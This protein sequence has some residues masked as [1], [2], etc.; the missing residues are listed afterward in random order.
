MPVPR[1]RLEPVVEGATTTPLELFFDLV[2]VFAL[3]QVTG[4]MAVDSGPER[5]FRGLLILGL[6]WWS[7]VGYAWLGNVVKADEGGCRIAVLAATA[8]MFVIALAIPRAFDDRSGAWSSAYILAVGY[9]V[10]R[11]VHLVTFWVLAADDAA[12]RAQLVRFAA[13]MA[14]ATTLLIVAAAASGGVR[15]GL[16]VTALVADYAGT[17][18]GGAAGWRLRAASHFAERHGLI[19]LI[20]LGESVVAIGAGVSDRPLS[21]RIIAGSLLGLSVSAAL[22]WVYF[23][24]SVTLA[25]HA[26][27]A[28]G[29]ADRARLA[30]DAYSFLHLPMVA[31]IALAA[32]GLKKVL[33]V[34]SAH[35]GQVPSDPVRGVGLAA[36]VVGVAAYLV[37]HVA[38]L[39]RCGIGVKWHRLGAAVGV[40][41][42][43]AI[44]PHIPALATLAALTLAVTAILG[45][46]TRHFAEQR[47]LV[48]RADQT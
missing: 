6:M 35:G 40:L 13:S 18:L 20:A 30:R 34:L 16:W 15:T 5:T 41:P 11:A 9:F 48:R 38:F 43:L 1:L 37:A 46:E 25:E 12:L 17:Y 36:L 28:S 21:G 3:T 14:T 19:V 8:A 31:G 47:R 22:W 2:F 7:W 44:G 10:L 26:L 23:D 33:G 42:L 4:F 29:G 39:V 27:T 24:T 32:L 45:W